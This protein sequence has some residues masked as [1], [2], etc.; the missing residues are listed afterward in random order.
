MRVSALGRYATPDEAFWQ[1]LGMRVREGVLAGDW[2][3][4]IQTG[5]PG[6]ITTWIGAAGIQLTL[7]L[8]PHTHANLDWAHTLAWLSTEAAAPYHN[9]GVFLPASRLITI[10]LTSLAILVIVY[11]FQRTQ[12]QKGAW[13]VGLL[14]AIDPFLAGLSGLLISDAL[15]GLC[16]V[17]ALL[18]VLPRQRPS[19][20]L[21]F[22]IG[23]ITALAFLN[24]LPGLILIGCVPLFLIAK[25]PIVIK[26]TMRDLLIWAIGILTAVTLLL[27]TVWLD[28][29]HVIAVLQRSATIEVGK[30]IPTFFMGEMTADPSLLYYPLAILFRLSPVV[31]VGVVIAL[32]KRPVSFRALGLLLLFSS[33]FIFGLEQS[34]RSYDRY[35]L[36]IMLLLT[37]GAGLGIA[38][39]G[40]KWSRPLLLLA[41]A[42]AVFNGAYPLLAYNWLLGG[43]PVAQHILPIGWGEVESTAAR[44]I[45]RTAQPP[46]PPVF[47][48][49]VPAVAHF[50]PG[51]VVPLRPATQGDITADAWLIVTADHPFAP[52]MQSETI[53]VG[54]QTRLIGKIE[55]NDAAAP[56]IINTDTPWQFVDAA[57][58]AGGGVR[59]FDQT[60]LVRLLWLDGGRQDFTVHVG[61][62]DPAAPDDAPEYAAV[63]APLVDIAG[64]PSRAWQ[65]GATNTVELLLSLPDT[66]PEK[67]DVRVSLFTLAGG[68]IGV[69]A[70]DVFAGVQVVVGR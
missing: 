26:T 15:L 25:T 34:T 58:M 21:L 12:S 42:Y 2:S 55:N 68:R 32:F 59:V 47:T 38:A 29:A 57:T 4:V 60:M 19:T 53:A 41:V 37:I 13:L 14:L 27:P 49:N 23:T 61:I 48:D 3:A 43:R 67:Y 18:A 44:H 33:L 45:T 6:I 28:P 1:F 20:R 11:L 36:P 51:P 31:L 5:Q 50:Y 10:L 30:V 16:V 70:D 8:R 39:V 17:I 24:K 35:A 66:L 64:Q 69:Y 40:K 63:D 22:F 62:T 56:L 9:L 7:W 46:Y 54:G 65:P 52:Q